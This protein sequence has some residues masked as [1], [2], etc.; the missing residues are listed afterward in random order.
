MV[1]VGK[2]DYTAGE[3]YPNL[4]VPIRLSDQG[5]FR[6][7]AVLNEIMISEPSVIYRGFACSGLLSGKRGSLKRVCTWEE[8]SMQDWKAGRLEKLTYISRVKSAFKLKIPE[9]V[10]R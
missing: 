1:T 9:Q 6:R 8:S 4:F 2:V 7:C 10:K 5:N 3:L